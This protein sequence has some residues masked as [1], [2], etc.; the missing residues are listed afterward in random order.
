MKSTC[1][2][3]HGGN[4]AVIGDLKETFPRLQFIA[5]SHSPFI[6]QSL[7]GGAVINLDSEDYS[8]ETPSEQ[9]IEDVAENIMGV[10]RPQRRQAL[11]RT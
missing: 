10:D 9:S 3:T 8:P 7:N 11:S 4:A 5:T 1:T 6:V 2:C